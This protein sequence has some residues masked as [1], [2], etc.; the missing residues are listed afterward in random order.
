MGQ[1]NE[2]I[3]FLNCLQAAD[4]RARSRISAAATGQLGKL[5]E[6]S[7]LQQVADFRPLIEKIA[8][9]KDKG[10]CRDLRMSFVS[11]KMFSVKFR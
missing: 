11:W 7:R 5:L 6:A 9:R 3:I 4:E 1:T 2:R 10:M 8:A